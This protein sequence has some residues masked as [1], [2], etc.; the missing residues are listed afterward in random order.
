MPLIAYETHK[1]QPTAQAIVKVANYII[2]EYQQ[3]G[4]VLTLRQLYYQMVARDYIPNHQKEYDR[5]SNVISSARRAGLIDWN[6]IIDRTRNIVGNSHQ[7]SP[8]KAI[9]NLSKSYLKSLWINQPVRPEIWI[10]KDAAIGVIEKVCSE[11][12]I[13]YFS[14]RGYTSD[15]E[16]WAASQRY[17]RRYERGQFTVIIHIGDHDP[18]GIDMT[19]DIRERL[20]LFSPLGV[21]IFKVRRVALNFNQVELYKPPPNPAKV[22][23][24]RFKGYAAK[25]GKESWE[26]DA[27]EP[28]IIEELIR[29]QFEDLVDKDTWNRSVE[30]S[31]KEK[32]LLV[33]ISDNWNKIIETLET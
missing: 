7:T 22:S 18:S 24:S 13:S 23:D 20:K 3:Q 1:F 33:K 12:D 29:E 4:F 10:E 2:S 19:R 17:I 5:L 8:S 15:S 16:M 21:K 11:L 25:Y 31:N 30:R 6:A 9:A 26:L 32:E 28:K 14:C 27:L